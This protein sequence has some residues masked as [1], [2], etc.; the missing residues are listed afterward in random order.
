MKLQEALKQLISQFGEDIVGDIKLANLLAD[1]NAYGEYPA[2]KQIFKDS[3]KAGYGEKLLEAYRKDKKTAIEKALDYS[4]EFAKI[5]KYKQDLV[6]YGF[7]SILFGLGCLSNI[8]EPLSKG[9][10]P[11]SKADDNILDNLS[12]LLS[13]CQK[14]YLDLLDRLITLPK[15][16]LSDAPGFYS[17]EALN[18]L[19]AII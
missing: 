18:K 10:D 19:Y 11:Y 1:F 14:Q 8:N 2:M 3:Q 17:T 15:D 16:I 6:S 12:D 9:F 5:S 13:S 7:D 4:Q